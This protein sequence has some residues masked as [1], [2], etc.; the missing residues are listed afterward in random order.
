MAETSPPASP[1]PAPS[2]ANVTTSPTPAISSC[3]EES[4]RLQFSLKIAHK[5]DEKNFHLWCQQ[6]EPYINSHDLTDLVV[7]T[8]VPP[9]FLDD[10]AARNGTVNP[11]Y[12]TWIQKDHML[13]LWLQSTL[14]SEVLSHVLGCSHAHQLLDRLFSYFQKQT[15]A[16]ARHLRVELRAITLDSFS[17]QDYLHKIR[18]IVDALTSIG[19]PIPPSH[20]IDVI[21]EGLT[22]EYA[23][24][25]S[26][27]ESKFGLV[28][29]MRWRFFSL[30]MNSGFPSFRRI[31]DLVS[32]N[33]T[34]VPPPSAP[35]DESQAP[36]TDSSS[37]QSSHPHVEP[38]YN[39]FRGGKSNRGGRFGRSR[40]GRISRNSNTQCQVCS[41]FGH[42][43][44]TCWHRFNSQ[45]Q[46]ATAGPYFNQ[47]SWYGAPNF[48]SQGAPN[49]WFRSSRPPAMIS[50][51][52]ST[53]VA[54]TLPP[55]STS[56]SWFPDSGASFHVTNDAKNIQQP[57][58]F[59]EHDQIFVG[60]GQ[61]LNI[62]SAGVSTVYAPCDSHTHTHLT[63]NNLLLV[64]KI[65]KNLLS[66]SQFSKDNNVDFI[67]SANKCLVKS[68]VSDAI[69]LEGHVGLDGL[70]VFPTLDVSAP[71]SSLSCLP[72]TN[73]CVPSANSVG[74]H[75]S[76]PYVWHLRLGHPN[77]HTLELVLQNCNVPFPNKY[78]E[79]FYAA[80]C[81]GKTHRLPSSTS[82]TSY[83]KPLQLVY[84]D[85][86]G[87]SPR[88]SAS[89]YHYLLHVVC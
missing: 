49:V 20:H 48:H 52:P 65:I 40:G 72:S 41:K 23:P 87:P 74:V 19:Y 30:H 53:F 80:C 86:W 3:F 31:P 59:E 50:P 88:A 29:L 42:S 51:P 44:L 32:L 1:T 33:L 85:L 26:V 10:K 6:V 21:L 12:S 55:S 8:R 18:T 77:V 37:S 66:A 83:T 4:R 5:L 75:T 15:R 25:V 14:S 46:P 39:S 56:A 9:K 82:H 89:G 35:V 13:L 70:Y 17:V 57:T 63:L 24:A 78:N 79:L 67:F 69:L 28:I 7:C 60:N 27:V 36:N 11:V 71:S 64:P 45:F 73:N 22:A 61:G 43:A 58:P 54:N 2:S 68:Q 84:T 16:R 62:L 38:D 34:H 81:M 47:G 76:L